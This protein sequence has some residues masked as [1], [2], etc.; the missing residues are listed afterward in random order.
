VV[1]LNR[2]TTVRAIFF[3]ANAPVLDVTFDGSESGTVTSS[4]AGIDCGAAEIC[5]VYV[6]PG[7]QITLSATA[8]PGSSFTG[9]SAPY[10]SGQV[11]DCSGAGTTTPTCTV[12]V[13]E[14]TLVNATFGTP[15]RTLDVTVRGTGSGTVTSSPAG[16]DC[17]RATCSAAFAA[18]TKVTLTA[19]PKPGST[20]TG[21]DGQGCG[22]GYRTCVVTLDGDP[23]VQALF[24]KNPPPPKAC[25]VPHVKGKK[26]AAAKKTIRSHHCGVG[27]ITNAKSSATNNGR[28][29]WESPRAGTHLEH[30]ARVALKVGQLK[31]KSGRTR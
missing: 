9:W 1:T 18:G 27:E 22:T 10:W 17:L 30:G 23:A 21:W 7:T 6:A 3:P 15:L 28:V 26:L 2:D 31:A 4:P 8:D 14:N 5:S 20:F 11:L 25:V 13:T 24:S 29:I 12:T 19:T 16:I